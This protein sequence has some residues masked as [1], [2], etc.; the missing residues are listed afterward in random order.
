MLLCN[1]KNSFIIYLPYI[2]SVY[3]TND[4]NEIAFH[5]TTLSISYYKINVKIT[6][7]LRN[8]HQFLK[9][10]LFTGPYSDEYVFD[11]LM[12]YLTIHY[13]YKHISNVTLSNL[14]II[15]SKKF[16]D[17]EITHLKCSLIKLASKLH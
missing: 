14:N 8:K 10:V 4:T 5:S 16:F 2:A 6:F 17:E 15:C 1:Y 9:F 3:Y 12:S 7:R 11:V 13:C